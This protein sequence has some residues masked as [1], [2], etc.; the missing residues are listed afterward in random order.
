MP[1]KRQW[2]VCTAPALEG[3][4]DLLLTSVTAKLRPD[5]SLPFLPTWCQKLLARASRFSIYSLHR[6][7]FPSTQAATDIMLEI[8]VLWQWPSTR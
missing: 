3:G 1:R 8:N 4:L 6:I 2:A 7:I 5:N